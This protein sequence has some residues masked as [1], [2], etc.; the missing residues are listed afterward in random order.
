MKKFL[1][2][3]LAV[4]LVLT[5]FALT[6]CDEK[7]ENTETGTESEKQAVSLELSGSLIENGN[8]LKDSAFPDDVTL[9]I[10]YSDDTKGESVTVTAE[11]VSGF[12]TATEGRKTATVSYNE[13]QASVPYRVYS[14]EVQLKFYDGLGTKEN[15]Y[16]I[17]TAQELQNVSEALSASY[18]LNNDI[19]LTDKVWAPIGNNIDDNSAFSGDFN[20]NGHTVSNLSVT[21]INV[22]EWDGYKNTYNYAGMFGV[23]TGK[24]YDLTLEDCTVL[25]TDEE[26]EDRGDVY[27]GVL[28]GANFGTITDVTVL[29]SSVSANAWLIASA[30]G[31]VGSNVGTVT[32]CAADGATVT[33]VSEGWTANAGGLIGASGDR[34]YWNV[35]ATVSGSKAENCTVLAKVTGAATTDDIDYPSPST[36]FGRAYSGGLGGLKAM[37]TLSENTV[38]NNTYNAES[39]ASGNFILFTGEQWGY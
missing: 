11:M 19:D 6:A 14:D 31:L 13:L 37:T 1:T 35:T 21:T 12:D 38:N 32:A 18:I 39:Y 29:N 24:V 16:Q 8:V 30:G 34:L 7:E 10:V 23:V 9:K 15:P 4:M 26:N 33:A 22:A 2:F 27:A 5:C 25:V 3:L 28:A 17:T 36:Y 20:G